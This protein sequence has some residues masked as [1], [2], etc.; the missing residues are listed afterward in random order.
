[1]IGKFA[2]LILALVLTAS[3]TTIVYQKTQQDDVNY[4]Q[5]HRLFTVGQYTE[6]VRFYKKALS[7][8]PRHFNS[9][10]ELG[11]CYQWTGR[12]I[13]AISAFRRALA[14]T[15]QNSQ[16]KLA[17]AET[18]SW[19]KE[20]SEAISLYQDVIGHTG[21]FEARQKLA[22]TYLWAGRPEESIQVL[23]RLRT[24]QPKD[25]KTKILL[26]EAF[27]YSNRTEEAI[28]IIEELLTREQTREITLQEKEALIKLMGQGYL[29]QKDYARAKRIFS[30]ILEK[31][32]HN[33]DV[34]LNLGEVYLYSG[35]LKAARGLFERVLVM[36]PANN[37][38]KVLHADTYAY[39]R[40]Y[41]YAQ[42]LYR[43]ALER[44]PGDNEVKRK[45]ADVLSWD[46]RYTEAIALYDEILSG[47]DDPAIRLQKA[48]VL[49]WQRRYPQALKAYQLLLKKR[50][51]KRVALEMEA[52]R[53]YWDNRLRH[54]IHYYKELIAVSPENVEARFD[55]A[56]IY[57]Y[58]SMWPE[59]RD[60][61]RAILQQSPSHFRATEGLEKAKI[62]SGQPS[63]KSGYEFF[64]AD[65]K[66]RS[67]DL[68]RHSLFNEWDQPLGDKVSLIGMYAL[69]ERSF[70]DAKDVTENEIKIRARYLKAPDW[71]ID[72][73]YGLVDYNGRITS[74]HTFGTAFAFRAFDCGNAVVSHERGRLENNSRVIYGRF[75]SDT[76][77]GRLSFDIN[78]RLKAG[79]DYAYAHYSD[80]NA[81][82]EPG[83]DLL[84]YVSFEPKRLSLQYR[85]FYK[86][87]KDK[88]T[89]Y[90]SPKGFSTNSLALRWRHFLNKEEIFFGA[91]D[92]FYD[93]GYE[94]YVDSKNIVSHKWSAELSRDI[95]KH[96]NV[97]LRG[98][99][100]AS[101]A[102]VYKD[103]N[104][105]ASVKYFF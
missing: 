66:G 103:T 101:S 37:R 94:I 46:R 10:K 63:L 68:K 90:F 44:N 33:I 23:T 84:Y 48:R 71:S 104:I 28:K 99:T 30:A 82:H 36:D 96:L 88:V 26:A 52:K 98:Q 97:N 51:D 55:L 57:S 77:K 93:L 25:I 73:F 53:A 56:Q 17:L 95:N 6:A 92:Y 7:A 89:D 85:Y 49:G 79:F 12:P 15:P 74:M 61:Y 42:G 39:G 70:A 16:V 60:S 67:T 54:A 59:A 65:S 29:I 76:L 19:Q 13:Q 32:P 24:H 11:L 58:Q 14:I 34:L 75:Y 64:E 72:T 69:T 20:Y 5:G 47:N 22:Q 4:Y 2:I 1:M 80:S 50:Y 35:D 31:Y 102:D 83:L 21:G 62:V 41:S 43:K 9:I 78:R 87:Y 38:A 91:D 40:R 81:R 105:I 27:M 100:V 45:L 86:N 8:N 18:L 3:G